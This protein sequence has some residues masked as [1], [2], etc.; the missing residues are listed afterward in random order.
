[1]QVVGGLCECWVCTRIVGGVG[2]QGWRFYVGSCTTH[3]LK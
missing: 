2:C 3:S 1:M